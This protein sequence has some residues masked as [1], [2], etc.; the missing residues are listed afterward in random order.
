M[1]SSF[2]FSGIVLLIVLN[3]SCKNKDVTFFSPAVTTTPVS[4]ILYTSATSGGTV[5]DDGGSSVVSR[6]V[7][8][9]TNSNPT[10][11]NKITNDGG[12]TGQFAS[13][14]TG[15][16][17]GETYFLR[18]YAINSVGIE[19]GSE[20]SFTTHVTGVKFNSS[21]TYGTVTDAEGNNYKTIRIE[22]QVWMAENLKSTKLNDGTAI[23]LV[24]GGPEWT[25]LV[26]P[27]YCWFD[28]NDTLYE[29][30]YGACYNWFVVST[31]KICPAGWHIPSDSEWQTMINFLGGNNSAGSKIKESG[32]NNWVR[33]N[34]DATNESGFTAL[35]SGQ[36]SSL[37]GTFTGKGIYGGW[38]SATELFSSPFSAA[39]CRWIHADTTVV[40]HNEIFKKDGFSIRCLK[41]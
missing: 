6:G 5:A 15:L 27:A 7:C 39:W 29:N 21:L 11:E 9:G 18:A 16:S 22:S 10:I 28:N 38:W 32:T 3:I 4:E 19:Y 40:A 25:N 8:W 31:G 34:N 1:K 13:S 30:I 26:T 33:T 36:R 14:L 24:T 12:G 35:P 2:K 17:I 37:D 20:E 23:P 41:D